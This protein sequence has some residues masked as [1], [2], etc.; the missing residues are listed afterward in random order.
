MTARKARRLGMREHRRPGHRKK[1][2][3]RAR[4]R[5]WIWAAIGLSIGAV[6]A[7][8]WRSRPPDDAKPTITALVGS[9]RRR[10]VTPLSEGARLWL[11]DHREE[12][13]QVATVFDVSPIAL[14]GIVAAE[15]TLLTGRVDALGDEVIQVVFGSL[16]DEDVARWARE[17]EREYQRRVAQGGGRPTLLTP[18]LWTLGPAQVSLRLAILYEPVVAGRMQRPE[19]S[20]REV[21]EAVTT[22]AGNLEYAAALLAEAQRAYADVAEINIADDPGLLATLYQLGSPT[23]RAQ[24]LAEDNALRRQRGAPLHAPRMNGYGAFVDHHAVEIAALLELPGG[25]RPNRD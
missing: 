2:R 7:A 24:R 1:R 5:R 11:V 3:S 14:G 13:R 15:K 4:G 21:L 23:R 19:R 25:E 9:E 10:A 17:Q 16:R 22:T 20:V 8:V 12:V 18:Y 6:A